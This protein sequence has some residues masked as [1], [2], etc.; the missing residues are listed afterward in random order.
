MSI[1]GMIASA[2]PTGQDPAL[3]EATSPSCKGNNDTGQFVGASRK[4]VH[5]AV[6]VDFP[7]DYHMSRCPPS[8]G[9]HMSA[10]RP[11]TSRSEH[12][13]S[14]AQALRHNKR[15]WCSIFSESA[16]TSMYLIDSENL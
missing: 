10:V 1:T 5:G 9:S 4:W 12:G 11:C 7:S 15:R 8:H 2:K 13:S 14:T 16:L 3:V 6:H